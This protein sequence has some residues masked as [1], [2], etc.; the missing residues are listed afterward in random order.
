M[1]HITAQVKLADQIVVVGSVFVI[2]NFYLEPISNL[3]FFLLEVVI[4]NKIIKLMIL[5]WHSLFLNL[6]LTLLYISTVL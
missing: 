5:T 2:L 6:Y 4:L 1:L 3:D